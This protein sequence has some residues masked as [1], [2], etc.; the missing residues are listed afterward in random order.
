MSDL[1]Y[2]IIVDGSGHVTERKLADHH[3]GTQLPATVKVISSTVKNGQRIVVLTRA[4][5]GA[6]ED[7]FTFASSQSSI[8]FINA[9]G[10][11]PTF[12]QHVARGPSTISL[13]ELGVGTCV[14]RR[15]G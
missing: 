1:P 13:L 14:C 4:L 5:E 7:Y 6:T 15:Q 3:A 10:G 9:I 11:T 12:G 2:A 8:S